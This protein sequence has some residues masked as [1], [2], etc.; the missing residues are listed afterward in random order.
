M[1]CFTPRSRLMPEGTPTPSESPIH[2]VPNAF[3]YVLTRRPDVEVA[4]G[5]RGSAVTRR[6]RR[7][8]FPDL[9]Q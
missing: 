3:F 4:N 6:T 1:M 8:V 7:F 9:C 5:Q 2:F